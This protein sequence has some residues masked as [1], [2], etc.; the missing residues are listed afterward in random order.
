MNKT[1]DWNNK[2]QVLEQVKKE[3]TFLRKAS[4]ELKKDMDIIKAAIL[5]TRYAFTKI[6]A[7]FLHILKQNKPF[8]LDILKI[9]CFVLLPNLLLLG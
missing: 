6:D 2:D 1:I 3:G 4:K 8:F 7:E 5:N 9:F